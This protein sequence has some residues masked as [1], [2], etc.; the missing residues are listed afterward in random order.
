MGIQG[1]VADAAKSS[2]PPATV[3]AEAFGGTGEGVGQGLTTWCAA[4]IANQ[5][6]LCRAW[7]CSFPRLHCYLQLQE[8]SRDSQNCLLFC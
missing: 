4:T 8:P 1:G 2:E 5:Q 7:V 3:A 6:W